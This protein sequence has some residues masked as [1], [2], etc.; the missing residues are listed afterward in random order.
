MQNTRPA[1]PSRGPLRALLTAASVAGLFAAGA[2][3]WAGECAK[4]RPAPEHAVLTA[5]EGSYDLTFSDG[6]KG[7]STCRVGLGGQWL[8][9]Q[10]R[11]D[12]C[13]QG[14]E[15]SGATSYDAVRKRYVNVW[16]DSVSPVP[17]VSE[18]AYDPATKTL[19]LAGDM[20]TPQG[21][22]VRATLLIVQKSADT[23]TFTMKVP[24]ADGT[25][26]ELFSITYQRRKS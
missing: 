24:G 6:S 25:A 16:I 22:T 19:T 20:T 13:G 14:Y 15:G 10:V 18:G 21:K 11:A 4:F 26:V 12:F 2:A 23:R 9:E 3:L 17:L 7:T 1:R 5:C 8:Q